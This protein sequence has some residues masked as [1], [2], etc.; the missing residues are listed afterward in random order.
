VIQCG[1]MAAVTITFARYFLELT[2]WKIS[3]A[4]VGAVTLL[5][6]TVINCAGVKLGSRV[7]SALMVLRILAIALLIVAGLWRVH[8]PHSLGPPLLDQ[9]PSPDL[10]MA[11][12]AALIPVLF[13]YGGWQTANFIAAEIKEPRRNLSRALIIG[14]AGVALLYVSV[15]FVCLRALGA[16]GLANTR[17]PATAVM[18]LTLGQTGA[19]WIALGIAISTLGFLSQAILTAPRVYFA[20]ADDK[21]FFPAVAYVSPRTRVPVV[22]IVLQSAWTM[23]IAISGRYEQILNYVVAMDFLFF[24]LTATCLFVFRRRERVS[25]QPQTAGYRVP[26]HPLTTVVFIAAC[27]LVVANTIYRYPENTLIGMAI[28]LLGLPVYALWHIRQK[29]LVTA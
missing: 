11:F 13:A 29:S 21:L 16:A 5:L 17:V 6:L 25:S 18:R 4:V 8:A 14:V 23:V 2:G 22:A 19:T 24:G 9:P 26:G 15:N 3:E 12:A 1:G 27:W 10:L 7:Q 28:L 20:M